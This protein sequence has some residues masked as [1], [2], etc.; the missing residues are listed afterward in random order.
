[1][2]RWVDAVYAYTYQGCALF[3]RRLPADFG[4][5]ALPDH[6][7]AVRVS[8]PERAILELVSDC[9]MSS[10]EGMRLVLGALRTVRRPVL[11]RLLTHCHHLDIRLVLATLAGQLDAPWA[12]W[13]ERH[14]AARP[15]SAP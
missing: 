4:I 9:T 10:P 7:P 12:Q 15:L 14:L 5:T 3:D 11:E 8:V 1:M 6:H 2:P 13:V